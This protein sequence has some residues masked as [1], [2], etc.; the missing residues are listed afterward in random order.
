M[1]GVLE[2][3]KALSDKNRLRVVAA[4][5]KNEELCVCQI[6]EMLG[7]ATP[8]VSRHMSIL[9]GGSLVESRKEGRWVYYSLSSA[10]PKP[11]LRWIDDSLANSAAL[12]SDRLKLNDIL[13]CEPAELCRQQK[14]K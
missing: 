4:L 2:K 6:T 3:M 5:M 1:E 12:A 14:E 9:L 10:F 7:I 8:T 13:C 11:L